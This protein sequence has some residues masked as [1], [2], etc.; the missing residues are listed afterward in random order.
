MTRWLGYKCLFSLNLL[1]AR[2]WLHSL[3]CSTN[4]WTKAVHIDWLDFLSL[5]WS[6]IRNKAWAQLSQSQ[7]LEICMFWIYIWSTAAYLGLDFLCW[8]LYLRLDWL[9]IHEY[10]TEAVCS[11]SFGRA[12]PLQMAVSKSLEVSDHISVMNSNKMQADVNW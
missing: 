5:H 2:G 11:N 9:I 1:P 3:C 4:H 7:W 10:S 8:A 6:L 12:L